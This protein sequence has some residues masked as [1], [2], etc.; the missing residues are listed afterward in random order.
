MTY[1]IRPGI[2]PLLARAELLDVVRQCQRRGRSK[3]GA[4][5]VVDVPTGT[6]AIDAVRMILRGEAPVIYIGGS[7]DL[8][9]RIGLLT[10]GFGA[11]RARHSATMK[12]LGE[13]G[14]DLVRERLHVLILPFEN[15]DSLEVFLHRE[16]G[17]QRGRW[18]LLNRNR[19]GSTNSQTRPKWI[20]LT[21]E[22]LG[23]ASNNATHKR[24]TNCDTS[25]TGH[26][27]SY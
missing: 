19:G 27:L 6:G 7:N 1:L 4:Y 16:H 18:P 13:E 8:R 24:D 20:D 10:T 26:D 2:G 12:I 5:A 11:T 15:H 14:R 25:D 3:A 21:W 9:V 22:H 23:I 17:R